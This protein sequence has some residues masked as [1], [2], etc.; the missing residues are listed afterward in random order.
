MRELGMLGVGEGMDETFADISD[1]AQ[2]CR[3]TDCSHA[4]EPGCEVR[5]ALERH[6]LSEEHLQNYLKLRKESDFHDLSYVERRRKDKA[7]G[8]F[9]H[10]VMKHKSRP[11]RS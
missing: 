6:E 1:L 11:D 10:S 4:R 7:F 9:V 5:R 3:F 2:K 8:R